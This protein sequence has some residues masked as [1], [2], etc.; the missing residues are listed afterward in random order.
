MKYSS[1]IVLTAFLAVCGL[2][3][4]PLQAG[5][6]TDGASAQESANEAAVVRRIRAAL[7]KYRP[8][9]RFD[10]GEQFFPV[11]AEAI[12]NHEGNRL[13]REDGDL[14][15]ERKDRRGLSIRYLRPGEYPT[16]DVHGDKDVRESDRVNAL[17]RKPGDFE[18]DDR[19]FRFA[20]YGRIYYVKDGSRTTGAWLQY[21]FF[22]YYNDFPGTD[23]GDH[24]GDWEM[25]Q[26]LVN[27]EAIPKFAIYA[28]HG[29][30]LVAEW[31]NVDIDPRG[32]VRP[33]V[34]VALGSHA[35][36]FKARPCLQDRHVDGAQELRT[37]RFIKFG[38]RSTRLWLA[39]P[40][41]WGG[42]G[43]SNKS[44]QGP[45]RQGDMWHN[46][47]RFFEDSLIKDCNPL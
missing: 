8:V 13:V 15:K 5:A 30:G 23:F 3:L 27:A 14:I 33:I 18:G 45:Q 31:K 38:S 7:H 16:A 29:S 37:Y 9:L 34:Y 40:G 42:S 20:V 41:R 21:W 4:F 32:K 6:Q 25:V 43:G 44:P 28:R 35:S 19:R 39:W 24:E 1:K 47:T 46:P 22:Y 12:T 10:S 2:S 11:R 36:Y 17:G 26:I